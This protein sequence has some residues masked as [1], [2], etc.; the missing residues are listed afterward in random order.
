MQNLNHTR[1]KC[2]VGVY[3]EQIGIHWKDVW[4][5]ACPESR[6]LGLRYVMMSDDFDSQ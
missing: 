4:C 5:L 2:N 3:T 6:Q 1:N